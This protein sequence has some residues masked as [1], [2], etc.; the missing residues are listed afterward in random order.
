M[1]Y[2][3]NKNKKNNKNEKNDRIGLNNMYMC[4]AWIKCINNN[5]VEY[6]VVDW[7]GKTKACKMFKTTQYYNL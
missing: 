2:I 6:T 3:F 1:H 7:W 4:I 5:Q